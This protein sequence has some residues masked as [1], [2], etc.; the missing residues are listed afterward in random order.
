M[1]VTIGGNNNDGGSNDGGYNGGGAAGGLISLI[2]GERQNRANKEE[3]R[4]NRNFQRNMSNSAYQRG[5]IDLKKAGLNPMLA[6][7]QGGASTPGGAQAQ[8][9]NTA[10]G[11][12]SSALDIKRLKQ[13]IQVMSS[14]EKKNTADAARSYADTGLAN[15]SAKGIIYQNEGKKFFGSMFRSVND[16]KKYNMRGKPNNPWKMPIIEKKLTPKT[17]TNKQKNSNKWRLP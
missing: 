8:M 6:Y 7:S 10:E 1:T 3:A 5:V 16:H 15:A 2:G 11:A 14:Q 9:E 13:E 12:I 4:T 17:N